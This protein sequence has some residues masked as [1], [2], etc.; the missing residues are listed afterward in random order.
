MVNQIRLLALNGLLGLGI[1][2][3]VYAQPAVEVGPPSAGTLSES[4]AETNRIQQ[5]NTETTENGSQT[6]ESV[7]VNGLET[8]TVTG[9]LTI[10]Q[11]GI[12]VQNNGVTYYVRQL[13]RYIRFI[14]G[15]KYGVAV[16]L[17]GVVYAY[18]LDD[19]I[20]FLQLTNF[21]LDGKEY[22]LTPLGGTGFTPKMGHKIRRPW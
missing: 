17:Q 6:Q 15:L 2:L 11:G 22:D 19:T 16:S 9:N 14:E 1:P 20:K 10:V 3:A 12:A 5:G 13:E 18:P 8:I 21:T 4:G 7:Q